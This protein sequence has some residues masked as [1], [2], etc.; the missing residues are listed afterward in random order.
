MRMIDAVSE[1]YRCPWDYAMKLPCMEF[2][3]VYSYMLA[4]TRTQN[5]I[6]KA[7]YDKMKARYGRH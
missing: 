7:E 6:M 3:N 2:L 1:T 5:A 4:K